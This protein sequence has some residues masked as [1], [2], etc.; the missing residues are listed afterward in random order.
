VADAFGETRGAVRR[1]GAGAVFSGDGFHPSP[2]GYDAWTD[3]VWRPVERALGARLPQ[4][5]RPPGPAAAGRP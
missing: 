2:A 1:L 4:G 3:A 5:R